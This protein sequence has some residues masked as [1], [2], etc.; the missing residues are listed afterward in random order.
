MIQLTLELLFPRS[1]SVSSLKIFKSCF[2]G[3]VLYFLQFSYRLFWY[4]Y[5]SVPKAADT[6]HNSDFTASNQPFRN[7]LLILGQQKETCPIFYHFWQSLNA[8][9]TNA[10]HGLAQ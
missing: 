7:I 2:R 5:I 1:S 9:S 4:I 6:Y 3:N 10:T 8:F